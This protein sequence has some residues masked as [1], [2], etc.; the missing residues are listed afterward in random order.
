MKY[1]ADKIAKMCIEIAGRDNMGEYYS[2]AFEV[3]NKSKM[4]VEASNVL[5]NYMGIDRAE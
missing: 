4:Y 5:I 2:F 3:Y 1:D